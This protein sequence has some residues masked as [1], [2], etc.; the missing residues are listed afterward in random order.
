MKAAREA[1]RISAGR[2]WK[3]RKIGRTGHRAE[4]ITFDDGCKGSSQVHV[5]CAVGDQPK[6]VK[7]A[8]R[9]LNR[10]RPAFRSGIIA[11]EPSQN[12][13]FGAKLSEVSGAWFTKTLFDVSGTSYPQPNDAG[14]KL[15]M[16]YRI[17]TLARE[18]SIRRIRLDVCREGALCDL[19]V[20]TGSATG[21]RKQQL[22]NVTYVAE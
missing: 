12:A 5:R 10:W 21:K 13:P 11:D 16:E 9:H 14:Q 8:D 1:F 20:P 22:I 2:K 6:N 3:S 19:N 15:D 18:V 4:S 7:R 17:Q